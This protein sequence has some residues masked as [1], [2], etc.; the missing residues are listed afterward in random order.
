[1]ADRDFYEVLGVARDADEATL[2]SAFRRLAVK[3][4]PD[5]NPDDPE[6]EQRFKEINEAYDILKD[7]EKRAAYDRFGQAAFEGGG[8]PGAAGARGFGGGFGGFGG[9]SDIFDE[10][11]S[12]FGG[13]RRAGG[14]GGAGRGSDLRFDMDIT[15]E[16]AFAGK[17][18]SV[19]VP[20]TE[21]CETCEG[22]G[23]AP[24]TKPVTCGSC[25]GA[26]K[27]RAQQG[28]FTI[29][30][31]CPTCGGVGR[32]IEKACEACGGAGR[33]RREKTLSVNIPA[34]VEDGTR[35]RL[36]GEGE[37]GLRGGPAGDLYLFLALEPHP[38]FQREGADIFCRVPIPM[39]TA[40]L[41]GHIEAPTVDGGRAR[42]AIPKGAQTGQ[43]FRLRGKGMTILRSDQRGDM[44]VEIRV[45]TPMNLTK[46]QEEVLRE[47]EAESEGGGTSPE[48]EGFFSRVKEL[49]DDLR[50]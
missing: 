44:Y 7:P 29:E 9:F 34:G 20:T 33:T 11:F 13:G 19:R 12:E 41:G 23:A 28:F 10:I 48:S 30:R 24:G 49:W 18:A 50:D 3:H 5:K 35:I 31:T 22:T 21:T 15:L 38:V 8:G 37:A 25:R 26:G 42:I 39:T 2:K 36:A 4:H 27:V 45:E 46:R 17:Q 14:G 16:D 43:Q 32:V 1:M 47:F 6:A 40:A